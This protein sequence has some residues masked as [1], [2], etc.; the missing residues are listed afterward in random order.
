MKFGGAI[1]SLSFIRSRRQLIL[2]NIL[3]SLFS[4]HSD[5]SDTIQLQHSTSITA[6]A[7]NFYIQLDTNCGCKPKKS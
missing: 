5:Y 2:S 3:A 7:N 1:I 4:F 6:I